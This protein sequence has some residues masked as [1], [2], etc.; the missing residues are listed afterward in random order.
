[1]SEIVDSD[2]K[3]AASSETMIACDS[4]FRLAGRFLLAAGGPEWV[5][6]FVGANFFGFVYFFFDGTF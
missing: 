3:F 5:P 4:T 2:G 1:M 6:I